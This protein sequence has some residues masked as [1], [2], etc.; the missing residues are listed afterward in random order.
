MR[1]LK[2]LKNIIFY[3]PAKLIMVGIILLSFMSLHK[4][5]YDKYSVYVLSQFKDGGEFLYAYRNGTQYSL[6]SFDKEQKV[7]DGKLEY[8]DTHFMVYISWSVIAILGFILI[9]MSV[10]PE[11]DS[12]WNFKEIWIKTL[13]EF[14]VCDSEENIYYYH[15]DGKL[16]HKSSNLL[17]NGDITNLVKNFIENKNSFPS[18]NGTKQ[19]IRDKKLKKIL[20]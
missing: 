4:Y 18:F 6:L 3:N 13:S 9:L 11:E 19:T 10:I 5:E 20:S 7:V 16:L 2:F 14:V 12:Q 1:I 8:L 17:F 15:L